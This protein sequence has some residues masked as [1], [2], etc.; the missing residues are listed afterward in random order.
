MIQSINSHRYPYLITY[1]GSMIDQPETIDSNNN[2]DIHVDMWSLGITLVEIIIGQYLPDDQIYLPF[3]PKKNWIPPLPSNETISD[4]ID[5]LIRQLLKIDW[6]ERPK[7]YSEIL[8]IPSIFNVSEIPSTEEVAHVTRV[9]NNI[10][11]LSLN[12]LEKSLYDLLK[13]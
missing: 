10:S 4:E 13:C 12:E 2:F 6:H 1:Y 7:T 11:S 3:S 5:N 8:E 9:I